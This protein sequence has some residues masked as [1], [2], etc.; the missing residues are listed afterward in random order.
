M[1]SYHR[2][3][4]IVE[5]DNDDARVLRRAAQISRW[6]GAPLLVLH[7]LDYA[8]G[9]DCDQAPVLT[10]AQV[11]SSLAAAAQ[12]KIDALLCRLAATTAHVLVVQGQ[13]WEVAARVA[14]EWQTDLIVCSKAARYRLDHARSAWGLVR[15]YR[16]ELLSVCAQ[17]TGFGARLRSWL[18]PLLQ[19]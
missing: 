9:F 13:A 12:E 2:I 16:G 8:P 17:R 11:E 19:G 15:A 7:V 18:H 6:S 3:L 5:L 1:T 14:Q 10:R 4:A